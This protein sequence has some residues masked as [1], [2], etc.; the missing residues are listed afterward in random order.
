MLNALLLLL[1]LPEKVLHLLLVQQ[2]RRPGMSQPTHFG[3]PKVRLRFLTLLLEKILQL[4]ASQPPPALWLLGAVHLQLP[5]AGLLSLPMLH[6]ECQLPPA[7]CLLGALFLQ[8]TKAGL[9][10]LLMLASMKLLRPRMAQAPLQA[11]MLLM[12]MSSMASTLRLS[13]YQVRSVQRHAFALWPW[14]A[15]HWQQLLGLLQRICCLACFAWKSPCLMRAQ[16]QVQVTQ[17]LE[18]LVLQP[19]RQPSLR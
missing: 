1:L 12:A 14:K 11:P 10:L 15:A 7:L 19:S 9:L 8:L 17:L 16:P 18:Q 5:K 4:L 2:L 6:L 3:L 13:A